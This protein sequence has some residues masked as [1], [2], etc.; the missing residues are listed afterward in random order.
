V[1]GPGGVHLDGEASGREAPGGDPARAA[2]PVGPEPSGVSPA[3]GGD[4]ARAAGPVGPEPSGV[5]PAAGG[6]PARAT[7]R[8]RA[9]SRRSRRSRRWRA[10]FLALALAGLVAGAAWVLLGSRLLAVRSVVVTGTHLVP[11]SEVLAVAGI[12]LGTPL[13]RVNTAQVAARVETI[14]QV[15]SAQV[16]RS[17]PDRVVIAVRERT[18]ALAV[19]VYGGG[20]DLVDADGVMVRWAARRPAGVPVYVTAAAVSS[21]RGDPDVAAAA[22]V[23]GE[24]PRKLRISVTSVTAPSPDQVTLRLANGATVLWGGTD[25]AQ[26][27]AEELYALMP[28]HASYYDVSAP[29]TAVTN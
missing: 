29:G 23:I 28:T 27:K 4:P 17:W 25:D 12:R 16:T 14:S 1:S 21:L 19:P 26:A 9:R 24:L 11:E 22:A 2:G 10:A 20:F 18:P 7:T 15:A 6:D 13:I 8:R 3:A 5:S